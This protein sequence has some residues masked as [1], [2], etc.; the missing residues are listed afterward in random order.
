MSWILC[1]IYWNV[2]QEKNEA[3]NHRVKTEYK[4][5]LALTT[6]TTTTIT[7]TKS[8]HE[9]EWEKAIS[10]IQI[11]S[12]THRPIHCVV[13]FKNHTSLTEITFESGRIFCMRYLAILVVCVDDRHIGAF[14][15]QNF[16][17]Y[18]FLT[19]KEKKNNARENEIEKAKYIL[20]CESNPSDRCFL[21]AMAALYCYRC[22]FYFFFFSFFL[23]NP[24]I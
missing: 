15:R 4:Y 5:G 1:I 2:S 20:C 7:N 17:F 3:K 18:F 13:R 11:I 14:K 8:H 19:K 16:W 9:S 21:A 23:F 10:K 12:H 6:K 22:P 24:V